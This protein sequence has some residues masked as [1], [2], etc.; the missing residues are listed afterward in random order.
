[1]TFSKIVNKK[2]SKIDFLAFFLKNVIGLFF[3]NMERFRNI[4]QAILIQKS[5]QKSAFGRT[6]TPPYLRIPSNKGE[7]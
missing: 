6:P 4:F 5:T 2:Y 7:S 1:M 3:L